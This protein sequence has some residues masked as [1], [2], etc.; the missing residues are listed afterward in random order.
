MVGKAKTAKTH[1]E[2]QGNSTAM[3]HDEGVLEEADLLLE[4]IRSLVRN[5]QKVSVDE[6]RGTGTTILTITVDP[7]DRGHIIGREGRTIE[8][9]T[10]IFAKSA[11]MEGRRTLVQLSGF[12]PGMRPR[13][14]QVERRRSVRH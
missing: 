1:D 9:I 12:A 14:P 7:S 5:P 3:T 13:V 10:H 2:Y 4:V 6:T 8:A 11:S